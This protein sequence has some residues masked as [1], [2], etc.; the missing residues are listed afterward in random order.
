MALKFAPVRSAPAPRLTDH[1][2]YVAAE[3][4]VQVAATGLDARMENRKRVELEVFLRN[5]EIRAD[6]PHDTMLRSRLKALQAK[7]PAAPG[8]RLTGDTPTPALAR[9]AAT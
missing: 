1:P 3:S 4:R 8:P 9:A 5:K 7:G 6:D 2:A